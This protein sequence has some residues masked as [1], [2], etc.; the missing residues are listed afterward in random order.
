V[1]HRGKERVPRGAEVGR[2][3]VHHGQLQP[4][5][6][7]PGPL[8]QRPL[9]AR[10]GRHPFPLVGVLQA[11]PAQHLGVIGRRLRQ[12]VQQLPRH[13]AVAVGHQAHGAPKH[14]GLRRRQAPQTLAQIGGVLGWRRSRLHATLCCA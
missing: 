11:A 3:V 8:H 2:V 9:Q 6:N 14:L 10:C 7:V 13:Q 4:D 1:R 12:G 5:G